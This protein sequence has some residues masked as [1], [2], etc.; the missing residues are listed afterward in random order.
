MKPMRP[1]CLIVALRPKLGLALTQSWPVAD[2]SIDGDLY[3]PVGPEWSGF[4]DWLR[5]GS[6]ALLGVR[7]NATEATRFILDRSKTLD[8]AEVG[9]YD[10]VAIFFTPSRAFDPDQSDDQDL[11]YDQVFVSDSG[12]DIAI[13]FATDNLAD[14]QLE[15]LASGLWENL[16]C[17]V[18]Y[19]Q[20]TR[21]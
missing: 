12:R 11:L 19:P 2:L 16:R 10:D 1:G 4:Y 6:G 18:S 9:S 5:D 17:S 20:R 3:R 13:C 7:Y 8:Y 14:S 15:A 21:S